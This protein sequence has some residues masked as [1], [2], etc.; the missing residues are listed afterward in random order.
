MIP[1]LDKSVVIEEDP[2]NMDAGLEKSIE[3]DDRRIE[4]EMARGPDYEEIV[5][6]VA[7]SIREKIVDF[8]KKNGFSYN[9]RDREF[10]DEISDLFAKNDILVEVIITSGVEKGVIDQMMNE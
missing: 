9:E 6:D 2:I 10:D 3:E 4:E 8:I 1:I 5:D 7:T